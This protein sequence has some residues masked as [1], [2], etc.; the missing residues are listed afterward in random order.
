MKGKPG[1]TEKSRIKHEQHD[2]ALAAGLSANPEVDGAVLSL[3]AVG[4]TRRRTGAV[5]R[6][7]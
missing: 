4:L 2:P 5:F 1:K 6:A 3:S 7:I